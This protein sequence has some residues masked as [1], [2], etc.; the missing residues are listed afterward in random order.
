MRNLLLKTFLWLALG[1][2]AE[3]QIYEWNR[4]VSL[5]DTGS[6]DVVGI[7]DS[8]FGTAGEVAV[9][10]TFTG[11]FEGEGSGS[12]TDGFVV[13]LKD[14]GTADWAKPFFMRGF[15]GRID[16]AGIARLPNGGL[17]VGGSFGGSMEAEGG[18]EISFFR[19][20]PVA[21][22]DSRDG[23]VFQ[24]SPSGDLVSGFQIPRFPVVDIAAGSGGDVFVTGGDNGTASLARRYQVDGQLVW[25]SEVAPGAVFMKALDVGDQAGGQVAVTGA[26]SG[27]DPQPSS[28]ARLL[29]DAAPPVAGVVDGE[30]R[31]LSN[32]PIDISIGIRRFTGGSVVASSVEGGNLVPLSSPGFSAG[33]EGKSV[34]VT[35]LTATGIQVSESDTW[36]LRANGVTNLRFSLKFD[37][38]AASPGSSRPDYEFLFSTITTSSGETSAITFPSTIEG[39]PYP[40]NTSVPV[41]NVGGSGVDLV[42]EFGGDTGS[43]QLGTFA[44]PDVNLPSLSEHAVF[45]AQ[46]DRETGKLE[47]IITTRSDGG[48][49]FNFAN[50]VAVAADGTVRF[51]FD[52]DGANP[53]IQGDALPAP[54]AGGNA[55]FLAKISRSGSPIW[56]VPIA[57]PIDDS[58]EIRVGAIDTDARGNTWVGASAR[59][60]SR[61]QCDIIRDQGSNADAALLQIDDEGRLLYSRFSEQGGG[62]QPNAVRVSQRPDTV[63][64]GGSFF[65]APTIFGSTALSNDATASRGFLARTG[66]LTGQAR[67]IATQ[68]R[69]A[70]EMGRS[71]KPFVADGDSFIYFPLQLPDGREAIAAFLTDE[72]FNRLSENDDVSAVEVDHSLGNTSD[73]VGVDWPLAR[74]NTTAPI[75]PSGPYSFCPGDAC[76]PIDFYIIDTAIDRTAPV[77]SGLSSNKN[78]FPTEIIRA[79]GEPLVSTRFLHGTQMLSLVGGSSL[80]VVPNLALDIFPYDVF[81]NGAGDPTYVSYLVSAVTRAT[82][83][84]EARTAAQPGV[85]NPAVMLLALSSSTPAT[86]AA[87]SSAIEDAVARGITVIVAGGN[88]G[89]QASDYLPASNGAATS[90]VITVGAM[91]KFD[92]LWA[93]SN[94]GPGI[95]LLAPGEDIL[96]PTL[97]AGNVILSGTSGASALVAGCALE[98]LAANPYA[99][100]GA[101][102]TFLTVSSSSTLANPT[103]GTTDRVAHIAG[104]SSP[105]FFGFAEWGARYTGSGLAAA[106]DF[107]ADGLPNAQ[108]YFSGL[109]PNTR[110]LEDNI[111]AI[112][113]DNTAIEFDFLAAKYLF[114]PESPSDLRDGGKFQ[115]Q[116]STDLES[117][118]VPAGLSYDV[119]S[120]ISPIQMKVRATFPMQAGSETGFVRLHITPGS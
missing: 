22:P 30:L 105:T 43:G 67:Y 103:A 87:L 8:I 88:G 10:G 74:L 55:S 47:S 71:I 91:N 20:D 38:S 99:D 1:A 37:P 28:P 15:T 60:S 100:P 13:G 39:T 104:E 120:E 34:L 53:Q 32:T 26:I 94:R 14:D 114:D 25:N 83:I 82:L 118:G 84:H 17:I 51:A 62:T 48:G 6:A 66:L 33:P 59:G 80:G 29:I 56:A 115:L 19:S 18:Q 11:I 79:F 81:P 90:G 75:S 72:Q 44:P 119:K 63:Y 77:I 23:F 49:D 116:W 7:A 68:S 52:A 61:Y 3:A 5:G 85:P 117:W 21:V 12:D 106:A 57:N 101:I 46:L 98:C 58:S 93:G 78:I 108:E 89:G 112:S 86:S 69:E 95:E 27:G 40:L 24:L 64:V 45:L 111:V 73:K 107:D 92:K 31:I 54:Q 110:D 102:E 41:A 9:A 97:G 4:A 16:V 96:Q 70:F 113:L 35:P 50:D 42:F 36:R 76:V 2:G 109:I 65:G